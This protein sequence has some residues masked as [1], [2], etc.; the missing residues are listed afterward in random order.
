VENRSQEGSE[1]TLARRF[2]TYLG[3]RNI[4]LE[5]RDLDKKFKNIEHEFV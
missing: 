3:V 1:D 2:L 5:G 4:H